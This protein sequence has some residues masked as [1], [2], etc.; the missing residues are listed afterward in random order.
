ME[1]ETLIDY[2]NCGIEI[3]FK[4]KEKMY[5]ITYSPSGDDDFIS[6][7]EFYKKPT[8]VK[9]IDELLNVHCCDT[10]LQEIWKSLSE[11]DVWT[12]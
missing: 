3:E 2:I 7:C 9:T 6:F 4:Y 1:K 10:T 8:N 12:S 5:S 11:K